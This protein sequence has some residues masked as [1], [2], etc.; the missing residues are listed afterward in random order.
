MRLPRGFLF[1]VFANLGV[2]P[3][4][5]QNANRFAPRAKL[6]TPTALGTLPPHA[7]W[8]GSNAL[9]LNAFYLPQVDLAGPV[10]TTPMQAGLIPNPYVAQSQW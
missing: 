1:P 10:V 4:P 2:A 7:S 5:P 6:V 8:G 9:V 3:P